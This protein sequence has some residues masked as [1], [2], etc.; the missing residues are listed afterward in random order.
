MFSAECLV[1]SC[2]EKMVDAEK[3]VAVARQEHRR[4]TARSCKGSMPS[5]RE[6]SL[7]RIS[8]VAVLR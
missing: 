7:F 6:G 8:G 1:P 5:R 2:A 3:S 4:S